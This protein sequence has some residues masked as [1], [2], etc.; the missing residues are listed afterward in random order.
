MGAVPFPPRNLPQEHMETGQKSC[1]APDWIRLS[2]SGALLTGAILLLTGKRRPGL[3]V[4][5]AGAALAMAEEREL[6]KQ[7]WD[8]LPGYLNKTQRMLDQVQETVDDLASKRDK[9]KSILDK[10][11]DKDK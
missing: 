7:W 1:S 6:V 9:I 2:A 10:D 11:K 4:S 8:A 3:L 5:V